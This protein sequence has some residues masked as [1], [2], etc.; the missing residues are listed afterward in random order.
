MNDTVPLV[1]VPIT[2][3][4]AKKFVYDN[5]RHRPNTV[6]HKFSIGIA[7][8]SGI[9]GIV[10][11]GRP[12]PRHLDNGWTL[13]VTRCCTDGVKNGCSM[14]YGAAW[15]AAKALGYRKMITYTLATESGTSL[16][17]SGWRIVGEVK[18]RKKG[19]DCKSR[20]RVETEPHQ[21]KIRWE[22]A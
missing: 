7:D 20:P 21:A 15:R 4:E 8:D 1:L 19:W 5:H 11:V 6:G 17:A 12:G 22:A 16:K 3:A 14:L 9:R 10:M 18:K 13:E 2:L